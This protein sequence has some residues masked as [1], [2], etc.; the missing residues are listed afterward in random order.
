MQW[1]EPR[2]HLIR[3]QPPQKLLTRALQPHIHTS[4][5][6]GSKMAGPS[7][8]LTSCVLLLACAVVA[9][10][11]SGSSSAAVGAD[12]VLDTPPTV[13]P[14]PAAR[15]SSSLGRRGG[16]GEL[17]QPGVGPDGDVLAARCR[18]GNGVVCSD[19]DYTGLCGWVV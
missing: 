19:R 15:A 13:E 11:S 18:P 5:R 4:S 3:C 6:Q 14:S 2:A 8:L 10:A 17:R 9:Q 1:K 16:G 12:L 7:R